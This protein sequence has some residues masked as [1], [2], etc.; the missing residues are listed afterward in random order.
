MSLVN[1]WRKAKRRYDAAHRQ[2]QRKIKLLQAEKS[3]AEYYMAAMGADQLADEAYM[4]KI[5]PYLNE[6]SPD[7]IEQH[8]KTIGRDLR[9]LNA[10]DKR[11]FTGIEMA[12]VDLERVLGAAERLI[13]KSDIAAS[14]WHQYR[15]IYDGCVHRLMAA[16]DKFEA[17]SSKQANMEAK[18]E[19]RLDHAAILRTVGQRSRAVYDF[20]AEN[21]IA[22]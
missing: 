21:E 8:S 9:D 19:I 16:N 10:V 5:R 3:A 6:F 22:G 14:S 15:E 20:L 7:S 11:P 18:L 4:R 2:A 17:F 1:D 13:A 12:L